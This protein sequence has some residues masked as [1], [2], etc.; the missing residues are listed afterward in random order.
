MRLHPALL[1]LGLIVAAGLACNF[2]VGNVNNG[3]VAANTNAANT[4]PASNS[5]NASASNTSGGADNAGGVRVEELYVAKD[6]D[7]DE[8]KTFSP[9]DRTVYAVATLS[10]FKAGT[11][12]KFTWYAADVEGQTKDTKVQDVEYTTGSL[13]NKVS[14]HLTLPKDW[15]KGKYR[16][17]T[18]INGRPDKS[19]EYTVE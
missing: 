5:G 2:S 6:K 7:G 17:E 13:E 15:P 12:V 19:V 14:A 8:A 1:G 3:N 16:V 18:E 4:G 10:D 9:S 11:K